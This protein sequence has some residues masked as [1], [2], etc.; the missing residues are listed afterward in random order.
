[1]KA[2]EHAIS[3]F[4]PTLPQG[5]GLIMISG[6]YYSFFAKQPECRQRMIDMAKAMGKENASDLWILLLHL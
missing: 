3:A 5:A 2:L 4:H 6:E 1:L